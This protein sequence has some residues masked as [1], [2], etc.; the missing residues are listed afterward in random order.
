MKSLPKISIIVPIYNVEPYVSECIQSVMRQTYTG[1]ME[2]ILVD[3]C[4]TDKSIEIAKQLIEDYTTENQKSKIKNPISFRILHHEHNR[5]LSAAR[6]TGTDAATG[7]YIYYLDSD[8]YISEDCIEVL[9]QPLHDFAYGM[10][11][12][13]M[14]PLGSSHTMPPMSKSTGAIMS[15]IDVF[16]V[17]YGD[18]PLYAMAWNRLVKRSLFAEHDMSFLEGQLHEDELWTYKCCLVI[19]SLYIQNKT[20]YNYRMRDDSI[21]GKREKNISK[22]AKSHYASVEYVLAHPANVDIDL[23]NNAIRYFM[24]MYLSTSIQ[25][26][27]NTWP[28]YK[29]LRKRFDYHPLLLWKQGK[30]S[31]KDVKHQF[32]FILPP[33]LGY[34]YLKIRKLKQIILS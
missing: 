12:G 26:F 21:M 11:I 30:M 14:T 32:H 8:D 13:G 4:G 33:F 5:G 10:V 31:L 24:G 16:K 29:D 6:N 18:N 7:D 34:A 27:Q 3:D 2:C 19:E 25:L 1:E 20:T 28:Q 22:R 23:Q 9:T 17:W 15:N